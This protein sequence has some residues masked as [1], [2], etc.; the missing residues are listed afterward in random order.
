M[1]RSNPLLSPCP[2]SGR[3]LMLRVMTKPVA[4]TEHDWKRVGLG[5]GL[6]FLLTLLVY[7]PALSAGFIWDDDAMLTANLA[8]KA[9]QGLYYIWCSTLLVDYFPLTYTSFWLEW[10]IWGL[11]PFGY[12]LTNV[13]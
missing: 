12:H 3:L 1:G 10:R 8:V 7:L 5:A 11:H 2:A 9:P 6:I 4:Q 13:L